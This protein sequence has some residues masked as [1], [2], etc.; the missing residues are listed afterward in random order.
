MIERVETVGYGRPATEA[1]VRAIQRAK[2]AGPLHPV[3][4]LVGSNFVGLS[5]RRL[6]GSGQLGGTGLANVSFLTPFQLAELLAPPPI[7]GQRPLTNPVLGAAVRRSMADDPGPFATVVDHPATEAAVAALYSEL[8]HVSAPSL[9][10]LERAGGI[11][12][13]SVQFF[14]SVRGRLDGF[15]GE[16]ELAAAVADRPDLGTEAARVGSVVWFLPD[17]ANA[18]LERLVATVIDTFPSTAIVGLTGDPGADRPVLERCARVGVPID[19]SDDTTGAID[20]PTAG[21]VVSVADPDD[22]VRTAIRWVL[23]LAETG[24]PLDRIAIFYPTPDPYVRSLRQHLA[25][26]GIPAN[27]PSRERLADS[28]AGRTLLAALD[29]P[30]Q[31]WR[32]DR[33]MALVATAPVRNGDASV[34]PGSWETLSRTA[35]VVQGLADWRRKLSARRSALSARIDEAS[36]PEHAR[37]EHLE[38]EQ[39]D[40]DELG[41]FVDA[42]AV[43]VE[44]VVAAPTW[45]AKSEAAGSLLNHLLG[46]EPRHD[47]WPEPEQD[48]ATRVADALARLAMLDE[49]EPDPHHGVFLR[50]LS[51]ELEVGRGRD[52]RF[53]HGVAYGPLASAPGQ[54]LDAVVVLG[55][56]EGICPARRRDDSLLPDVA[57]ALVPRGELPLR[58]GR[59]DDQHRALLAALA[60]APPHRRLLMHPR[61]SLRGNH[62][63]LPSRW[64]LDTVSELA[65]QRL[66]STDFAALGEP[67]VRVVPS[68]AAGVLSTPV[69]SSL[70]ERDLAELMGMRR[71]G[72]DPASHPAATAAVTRGLRCLQSRHSNRFTEWDGNLEGVAIPSPTRD[73]ALM[74]ATGLQEWAECGF[75]YYL[76]HVLGLRD[77]DDPER[78][79]E[80]HP[81][82]RGHAVHTILERFIESVLDEGTP[83]P[84]VPWTPEQR[85]RA[86]AIA[87][88]VLDALERS[89]RTGR[90]VTWSVERA[91][92]IRMVD[93]FLDHDQRRR[94]EWRSRPV[95]VELPFGLDDADPVVI[96][97]PDGRSVNFRGMADRVDRTDDGRWIVLDYKTGRATKYA[98]LDDDP[99]MG[100]TTLQLGL[101]AEAARQRL[102]GDAASAY[103]WMLEAPAD[104]AMLGYEWTPERRARFLDLIA[105]MVDGIDN[106]V[107]PMVPGDLDTYHNAHGNCRFCAF[108]RVCPSDRAL[109]AEAKVDAPQLAVRRGLLPPEQ[110][111]PEDDT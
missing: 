91:R 26:A 101:Y 57:R 79:R 16:P 10:I 103:Y 74:S 89:G 34:R 98:K 12:S 64:L 109:H 13:V 4:V 41:S 29:L 81:F 62:R 75:R 47:R 90:P 19:T 105:A 14:R 22:E 85:D 32:R 60:S 17:T 31:Q 88:D 6:L 68:H 40:L 97:L 21:E 104:N 11:T 107:F 1:L 106:G 78:I 51:N 82:D 71:A 35:G 25:G 7:P 33:V 92:L 94:A 84:D 5:L 87:S 20:A 42:L 30:A 80:L 102:G 45:S 49:L 3:T 67:L 86:H 39:R 110:E 61:G 76:S 111:S 77:R 70:A 59:L 15:G 50:A 100:G 56:A 18:S 36:G 46:P 69:A 52:G 93:A 54:D 23:G 2:Q 65:G 38:R 83:A 73:G 53:G 72:I 24:V 28:V 99:F 9:D 37:I 27:G 95:R 43:Q 44:A 55:M 48:A 96:G 8:S 66:Y 63:H 58:A 108:D